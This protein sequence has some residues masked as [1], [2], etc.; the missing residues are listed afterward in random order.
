MAW[1]QSTGAVQHNKSAEQENALIRLERDRQRCQAGRIAGDQLPR[2][3]SLLQYAAD[4]RVKV[5]CLTE[6]A[7]SM[8]ESG[9]L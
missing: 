3:W 4:I 2:K 7:Q 9:Y 5:N 1:E 6:D 8:L